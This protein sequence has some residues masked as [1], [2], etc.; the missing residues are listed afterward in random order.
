MIKRA[1]EPRR[2]VVLFS[3][4]GLGA[5]DIGRQSEP[6]RER[7]LPLVV[8]RNADQLVDEVHGRLEGLKRTT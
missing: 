6:C 8:A 2:T 7:K 3:L 5:N 1:Y 4:E